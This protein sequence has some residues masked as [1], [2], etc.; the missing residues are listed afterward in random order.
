[1]EKNKKVAMSKIIKRQIIS[2]ISGTPN[3]NLF[4]YIV[5]SNATEFEKWFINVKTRNSQNLRV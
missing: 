2:N 4:H 5:I 1:M 3:I